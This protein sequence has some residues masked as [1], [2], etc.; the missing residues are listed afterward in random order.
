MTHNAMMISRRVLAWT[1]LCVLA[2]PA[3]AQKNT[4]IGSSV[5]ATVGDE[6]VLYRDVERAFQKNLT[7]RDTPFKDVPR[8]TALDFIRL[9][10]NYR[11]KVAS[12]RDRDMHEDPA[13]MADIENNRKLLSE[14]WYFDHAFANARID[15][16]ARRRTKE[17]KAA[18]I[19]CAVTN[20]ETKKWDTT[21]SLAK[22]NAIIAQLNAGANFEKLA[23]DSSDDRE[24]GE[25]GGELP[26]ISGG[27]I[28]KVVED[29]AYSMKVG[30]HSTQPVISRFGY[31][32]V[33]VYDMQPREVVKFRHILLQKKEDRDSAGIDALADSLL[34]ILNAKPAQQQ[35]LLR[36]RGIEPTDDA[37][38]DLAKKYS[39]DKVSAEKGGF[40]GSA[41]SRSGGMESNG[42]R[43]VGDFEK[44]V[45]NLKDGQISGKVH[46]VFGVHLIIRDS[47][48]LPD[49]QMERDAAKRTY[50]RLYFEDDK[51]NLYD[52]L[53]AE[54]G[55]RWVEEVKAK[56]LS[57]IDT[58]KNTSDSSWWKPLSDA[59]QSQ[60][61][62]ELPD[63]AS[64][65]VGS[66]VDSLRQR[67]DM[68]G[69]T[70]NSS[71][72]ERAMN[73]IVDPMVLDQ[74]TADLDEQ[75][76]EFKALLQEFSDGILLFKVEEQEVWSKLKFDTVGAQAFYDTTKTRWM[77]ETQYRL[78]EI[79]VLNDSAAQD[80]K[81]R[82]D[83]GGNFA[84]LAAEHTQREGGREKRGSLGVV[85]AKTNTAA[86]KVVEAGT[87]QGQVLGP[88]RDGRGFVLIR[89]DEILPPRQ[90]SFDEALPELATA[91]Q[92][93]LQQKLTTAWLNGVRKDHPVTLNTKTI[94]SIWGSK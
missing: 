38:S 13:V 64:I 15:E 79:F 49:E 65:T 72:F 27:S 25:S 78:S 18:I 44:A 35:K 93:A 31:F 32:I 3:V 50:R 48:R 59:F 85:T 30:A 43:L 71:G 33:K 53:K 89:V 77:T 21:A 87:K 76:P 47:T 23:R 67:M 91:Y 26:W 66:F 82:L 37:F 86:R 62:Y 20:P 46:T 61:V 45:F 73:K 83:K 2:L 69:Y 36:A 6:E 4:K 17:V 34:T 58:T 80:I 11:L 1:L 41:Y 5:L 14:T 40:L 22:A 56:L 63:G 94:N 70:L 74:A 24:T 88:I 55:Y 7:R 28:I 29:E 51:R 81:M 9:Y 8:D 12:A 84:E 60:D 39:D 10:T 75:Y 52:S 68:R 90:K 19:L 42:S 57:S 16:L 54:Y 92:D